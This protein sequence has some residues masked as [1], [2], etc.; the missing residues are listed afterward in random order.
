MATRRRYLVSAALAMGLVPIPA[1]PRAEPEGE[2]RLAHRGTIL[3][4]QRLD[5]DTGF[6]LTDTALLATRDGG[7]SWADVSPSA[8]ADG[9]GQ[10]FFLDP[11]QGYLAGVRPEAPDQLRLLATP[12]GGRSWEERAIPESTLETGSYARS[13]VHFVDPD[14]GWV[15]GQV[16]T[17]AAFSLAELMRTSDGGQTWERLPRPPAGG[18]FVFVSALRGFMV[19]GPVPE[20]LFRTENGGRSWHEVRHGRALAPGRALYGLPVF[21]SA[22]EGTLAVTLRG[23]VP[24]LSTFVTR[25]GGLT[26]HRAS[27][28]KLPPGDSEEPV[29]AVLDDEGE[30]AS[31]VLGEAVWRR[32]GPSTSTLR[33]DRG[34][35]ARPTAGVP[36]VRALAGGDGAAP[37]ALVAEGSCE[38]GVCRQETRLVDLDDEAPRDLLVRTQATLAASASPLA[39][40]AAVISFD[41]GFDKCAA[42]TVAQMQTWKTASPYEDANIYFGGSARGCAQ[43]NL[44]PAWVDAVFQQGWRL[45]PTWVGPQAP[46]TGFSKK[47]SSD[48]ATA[49]VEGQAEADAAV[50]AAALLGLG[51]GTPLYYDMEHYNYAIASCSAAVRSFVDGWTE[52]TKAH[53]YVAGMYGTASTTQADWRPG[54]IAHP[55]D[56]VWVAAWACTGPTCNFTPSVFGIPGLSDDYWSQNQRIRQY[57]GGHAET[58]GGVTFTI[59][60]NYANGPVAAPSAALPDVVVD[61]VSVSPPDPLPGQAVTFT[62]VVRNAGAGPTPAGV[63]VGVGYRIE[64]V[65]VTWGAVDGPLAP[66]ASVTIGPQGG[67]WTATA[68]GHTLDAVVDDVDRFAESDETNNVG[69]TTFEVG[70]PCAVSVPPDRWRGEY[71]PNR[72][73]SGSPV[74]V[75]DEGASSLDFA[76]G[77]GAPDGACGVPADGFS[78]RFTR[79][80]DFPSGLY[81]F[82]VSA[83]DGV[84]LWVGSTFVLDEWRDQVASFTRTVSLPGGPQTLTLEHYENLGGATIRLSWQRLDPVIVDDGDPGFQLLQT[85][86]GRPEWWHPVTGVGYGN[87]MV[88]TTNTYGRLDNYARWTPVLPGP[89]RYRV[90]AFIPS[91]NASTTAA[92]YRVVASGSSVVRVVNQSPLYDAWA[93]LGIHVFAGSND[94]SELVELGDVTGETSNSKRIGFDAIRFTP[95]GEDP[96]PGAG[97]SFPVGSAESGAGWRVSLPLGASWTSSS[98]VSYRGHLAEDWFLSSGS[99][100]GQTVYAAA[101]GEVVTALQNCGNYVDVVILRHQVSGIAEPVYSMYGH[102]ET[103]LRVGDRVTRRQAIGVLGNPVT[104]QPHLHFEIKNHTALVNV[105]FSSCS[106]V[107]RGVYIGAGYS[108]RSNDYA[109]GEHYDPSNDGVVDNRYYHPTRFIQ[110]RLAVGSAATAGRVRPLPLPSMVEAGAPRCEP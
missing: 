95:I 82:S 37:W 68:G 75:R 98:G 30:P 18:R 22:D 84:R 58:W 32:T 3:Q 56:A 4:V 110:S 10:V 25:N 103:T 97:W 99:S 64:G 87:D 45:I 93:D 80:V 83:D 42:A 63:P 88:W 36:A 1:V 100:L 39:P 86:T 29:P 96:V 7:R 52:R 79:T 46:C 60:T 104:F 73:L 66:G 31:V 92:R 50:Q 24:L 54:V 77:A 106:D 9:R 69:S 85:A 62:S 74:L 102:L 8:L 105:P 91:A 48:P 51:T 109:G 72:D 43:P 16:A 70:S 6:V 53:G 76:W 17:S 57:W 55:P 101:D 21:R 35:G 90:E 89:G 15:L 49:R 78:T 59:D 81:R 108:G 67:T 26:W 33:R 28:V 94:G 23:P 61:E 27:T 19:G 38:A 14:H 5:R 12:D 44:S 2:V 11:E 107:A 41:K 13:A 47:F 71:F 34:H 65:Q 20:R 40:A